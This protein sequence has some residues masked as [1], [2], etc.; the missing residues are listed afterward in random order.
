M[1]FQGIILLA[2]HL[3]AVFAVILKISWLMMFVAEHFKMT[4]SEGKPD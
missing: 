1:N 3:Q 2:K 4:L